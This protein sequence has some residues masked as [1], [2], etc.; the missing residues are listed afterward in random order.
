MKRFLIP[1]ALLVTLFFPSCMI[2]QFRQ[3]DRVLKRH[4]R[5]ERA[6]FELGYYEAIGRRVRYLV[7]DNHAPDNLVLV[8]GAP[9]SMSRYHRF[10]SDSALKARYNFYVIDRPGYGYSGFGDAETS[11]DKQVEALRPLFDRIRDTT[12]RTFMLGKSYGGPIAVRFAMKYPGLV[13]GLVLVAPAIQPGEEKT[14]SIS[15]LMVKKDLGH[16][17]PGMYVTASREKLAHAGELKKMCDDWCG[18]H[19]PVI[20]VQGLDDKLVYPSNIDYVKQRVSD[21]LLQVIPLENETHF[22]SKKAFPKLVE[23]CLEIGE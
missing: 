14:Y 21:S 16:L 13:D 9:G 17:F 23:A 3:S 6:N 11:I 8:H 22:F 20:M 5:K 18:L 15:Y 2:V 10:L 12:G 1:L 19:C 4:L 7:I